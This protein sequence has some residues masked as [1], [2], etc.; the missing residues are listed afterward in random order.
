MARSSTIRLALLALAT[1]SA[2][3]STD[4][5]ASSPAGAG[6]TRPCE[7]SSIAEGTFDLPY[8]GTA[9]RYIVHLPPGYD[10]TKRTP[11]VLNWHGLTSTGDQQALFS[12]MNPV[13][14]SS[15]F[16]VVYPDSPTNSWNAGT[17]CA[18]NQATRDDMGFAR[19]LVDKVSADACIDSKRIYTTGMSN[20]AFM[21]Y[22]LA[23]E[24]SDIFAAAAPVA[25]KVG[26][27]DCAPVRPVP[28]MH[29]HGT[30]DSLVAYAAPA[31][32]GEGLDVPGTVQKWAERDTCNPTPA[33]SYQQGTVTCNTYSGCKND[34]TVT[35]CTAEGEDHCWPGTAFCP[36][37]AFTTD[38]DA[39][40]QI[41]DFFG[42]HSLP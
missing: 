30:A 21:S 20:G 16:I 24:A 35:L 36:F 14:D 18:F 19:A 13:A 26:I 42:K 17:C 11:L 9:F 12:G 27:P 7:P 8:E 39:S 3:S 4:D 23:C 37:G 22:R 29:F 34:A 33:V 41:A 6:D 40:Q 28:I 15:G 38:I 10:G 1:S 2:C 25:G 31:L 5:P 32:S